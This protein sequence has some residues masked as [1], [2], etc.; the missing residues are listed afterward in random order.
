M[1]ASIGSSGPSATATPTDTLTVATPNRAEV[2][3]ADRGAD[4][5]SDFD[6]DARVG[7]PQQDDELL[8]AE[9]RRDVVLAHRRHD[10]ARDRPQHLVAGRMA[11]GV[12]EDLELVD[13]D[14]EDPDG[15]PRAPALGEQR[16]ELLEVAAVR[17]PGQ[18]IG[19]GLGLGGPVRVR[20]GKRG[21]CLGSGR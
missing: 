2:Q 13:V 9:A 16:D 19:R 3:A 14:H 11:V 4:A 15:V 20:A 7:V 6:R 17:Q 21:R 5:L 10:G 18:G 1:R 8:P 12:V